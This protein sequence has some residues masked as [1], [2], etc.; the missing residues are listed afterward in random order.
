MFIG[1]IG[2]EA[3]GGV[4]RQYIPFVKLVGGAL[5]PFCHS[6]PKAVSMICSANATGGVSYCAAIGG[7]CQTCVNT[8]TLLVNEVVR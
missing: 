4:C 3:L 6:V 7:K 1:G 5:S 8:I 2:V